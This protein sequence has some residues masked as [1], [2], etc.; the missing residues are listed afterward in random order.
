MDDDVRGV[1]RG[2]RHGVKVERWL[3]AIN[4]AARILWLICL[5]PPP[6]AFAEWHMTGL[7]KA[8]SANV[9]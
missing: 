7:H 5:S 3:A 1:Y 9:T 8:G 2:I 4:I 6:K